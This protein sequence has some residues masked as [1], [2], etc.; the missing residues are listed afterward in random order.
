MPMR[1]MFL[2]V[3]TIFSLFAWSGSATFADSS[4]THF[5][6]LGWYI[7]TQANESRQ[8]FFTYGTSNIPFVGLCLTESNGEKLGTSITHA[9]W[10]T[11]PS[12]GIPDWSLAG[13]SFGSCW[14]GGGQCSE[15]ISTHCRQRHAIRYTVFES[16][17]DALLTTCNCHWC[18]WWRM[19]HIK[20][21]WLGRR[22]GY[23]RSRFFMFVH[24]PINSASVI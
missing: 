24:V 1:L 20:W 2:P 12:Q 8:A 14:K 7:I 10:A 13:H 9:L 19:M 18:D 17:E 22:S 16:V 5:N 15:R 6:V 21:C 4:N 3:S 11:S 23:F